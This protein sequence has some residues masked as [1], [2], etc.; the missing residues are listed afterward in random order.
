MLR[1]L[2]WEQAMPDVNMKV[3]PTELKAFRQVTSGERSRCLIRRVFNKCK[4]SPGRRST[5]TPRRH[6]QSRR[7]KTLLAPDAHRC[8]S[9]SD[10]P[11]TIKHRDDTKK[12]LL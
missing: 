3:I 11:F 6:R 1:W 12:A 9:R 7:R 2:A 5:V 4:A 10:R 8:G